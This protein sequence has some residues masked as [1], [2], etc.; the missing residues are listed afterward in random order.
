MSTKADADAVLLRAAAGGDRAATATLYARA[1]DDA[2]RC[3]LRILGCPA[4]AEDAAQDA[5]LA[6]LARLPRLDTDALRFDAYVQTAASH[7]ALGRIRAR[8]RLTSVADVAEWAPPES[9]GDPAACL[10][11]DERRR[12]VR[13]AV[14]GLPQRQRLAVFRDAY[15]DTPRHAIAA[16]LD[17]DPNAVGQLLWRARRTLHGRLETAAA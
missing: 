10:E 11:A 4:E 6:C 14:R 9:D 7:A 16:E 13:A 5:L 17:L 1:F 2:R 12:L 8:R 15:E 3:C